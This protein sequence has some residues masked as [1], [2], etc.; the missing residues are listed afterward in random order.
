MRDRFPRMPVTSGDFYIT[1]S[2]LIWV[3]R[4]QDSHIN[5]HTSN[6]VNWYRP[7]SE[8]TIYY[9]ISCCLNMADDWIQPYQIMETIGSSAK[10]CDDLAVSVSYSIWAWRSRNNPINTQFSSIVNGKRNR[11]AK[12]TSSSILSLGHSRRL[13][14][15]VSNHAKQ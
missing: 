11:S 2:Y 7:R 9:R 5:T 4:C 8:K 12:I 3:Y 13:K 6:I 10:W 15:T 14:S 1:I